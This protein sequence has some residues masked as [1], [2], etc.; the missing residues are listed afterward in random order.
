ML[1]NKSTLYSNS[2][3]PLPLHFPAGTCPFQLSSP[4]SIVLHMKLSSIKSYFAGHI[5]A[6]YLQLGVSSPAATLAPS[7]SNFV[8]PRVYFTAHLRTLMH[9][10]C[11]HFCCPFVRSPAHICTPSCCC[12]KVPAPVHAPLLHH[13]VLIFIDFSFSAGQEQVPF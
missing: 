3:A 12:F 11:A 7:L 9:Q 4:N 13:F 5:D 6:V 8:P 1:H 10:A 2:K